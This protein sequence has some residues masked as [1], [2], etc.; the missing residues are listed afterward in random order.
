MKCDEVL[1]RACDVKER[2]LG[3]ERVGHSER[4]DEGTLVGGLRGEV[5]SA[6]PRRPAALE[7]TQLANRVPESNVGDGMAEP[8][9]HEDER[10]IDRV[11]IDGDEG[12]R[13][14]SK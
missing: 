12:G 2:V 7:R 10:G 13:A 14:G 4:G 11:G 1:A 3:A 5:T 6:I 8:G 9:L